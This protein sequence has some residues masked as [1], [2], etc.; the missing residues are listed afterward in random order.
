MGLPKGGGSVWT[1]EFGDNFT[2]FLVISGVRENGPSF[3]GGFLPLVIGFSRTF[4]RS[5]PFSKAWLP[6]LAA[7]RDPFSQ[8]RR[9]PPLVYFFSPLVIVPQSPFCCKAIFLYCFPLLL[10][11]FVFFSVAFNED[12]RF[13]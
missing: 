13:Y 3:H 8:N 1:K 6:P 11:L 5:R 7:E 12:V 10:C 9:V 4:S 2:S